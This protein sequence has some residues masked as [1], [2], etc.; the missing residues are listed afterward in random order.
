M[1]SIDNLPNNESTLSFHEGFVEL[2]ELVSCDNELIWK[3]RARWIKL[4]EDVDECADRWGKPHIPCLTYR[5]LREVE[6]NLQNGVFLLDLQADTLPSICEAIIDEIKALKNLEDEE[7]RAVKTLL[8]SRH[9]H[10]RQHK[11]GTHRAAKNLAR[12]LSRIMPQG[13]RSRPPSTTPHLTNF[14]ENVHSPG[15]KCEDESDSM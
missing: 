1:T 3:E 14:L 4:E 8:L 9:E 2:E 6:R 11:G 15:T 5:S 10:H 7:C 12:R 13:Q